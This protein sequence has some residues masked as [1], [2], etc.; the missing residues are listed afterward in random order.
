MQ[1]PHRMAMVKKSMARILLVLKERSL[2]EGKN[3][4]DSEILENLDNIKEEINQN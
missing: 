4:S 1:A 3:V 2:E